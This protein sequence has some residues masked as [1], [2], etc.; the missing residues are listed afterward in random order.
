[1][2]ITYRKTWIENLRVKYGWK[3]QLQTWSLRVELTF[4]DRSKPAVGSVEFRH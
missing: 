1:M 2:P 4:F 3:S